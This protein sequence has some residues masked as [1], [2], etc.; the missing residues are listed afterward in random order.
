MQFRDGADEPVSGPQFRDVLGV[1]VVRPDDGLADRVH[2]RQA[3]G[4]LGEQSMDRLDLGVEL[5]P[6][7]I[8]LGV[9][10]TKKRA[11][12]DR[13]LG[14]DLVDRRLGKAPLAEQA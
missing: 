11:P 10:V 2:H 9:E 5:R 4:S 8:R 1:V 13:C 6:Q 3:G 12:A 7:H 14:G